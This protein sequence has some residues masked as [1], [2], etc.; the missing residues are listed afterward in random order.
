[1]NEVKVG[2]VWKIKPGKENHFLDDEIKIAF[3]S[4]ENGYF[5]IR[6]SISS[7]K[8]ELLDLYNLVQET[9]YQ[10]EEHFFLIDL[11]EPFFLNG[12]VYIKK[13][14]STAI[15]NDETKLFHFKPTDL[16]LV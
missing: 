8:F 1:M 3:V 2:Q 15:T 5:C 9:G 11:E 10:T 6:E 13:S 16:C 14:D 7:Y 4:P 12:E